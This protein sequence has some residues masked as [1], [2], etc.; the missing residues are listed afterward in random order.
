VS[1]AFNALSVFGWTNSSV[2]GRKA[3]FGGEIEALVFLGLLNQLRLSL[4]VTAGLHR[5]WRTVY[6]L[7]G[8][9]VSS[10]GNYAL[11]I[12]VRVG[13]GLFL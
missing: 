4:G 10:T 2:A 6:E 11:Q 8:V 5:R 12:P 9:E 3:L 7:D 1:W 13:F